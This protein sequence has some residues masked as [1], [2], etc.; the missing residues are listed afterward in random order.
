MII[1]ITQLSANFEGIHTAQVTAGKLMVVSP[2]LLALRLASRN[3][4]RDA[5]A[6]IVFSQ[7]YYVSY[8]P[9]VTYYL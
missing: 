7:L 4:P 2:S 5:A 1:T 9:V 3:S 8:H 6:R